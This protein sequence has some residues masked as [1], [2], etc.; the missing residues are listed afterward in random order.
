MLA[1]DPGNTCGFVVFS[2]LTHDTPIVGECNSAE[3][4]ERCNA[5]LAVNRDLVVVV[6]AFRI[7]PGRAKSLSGSRVFSAE[8]LGAVREWCRNNGITLVEQPPA[9]TKTVGRTLLEMFGL[10]E[11]TKGLPHARDAARH[12]VAYLLRPD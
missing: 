8:A 11:P 4:V 6:E 9:V 2:G 12:L 7:I 5:V 10:W 1:I 3:I